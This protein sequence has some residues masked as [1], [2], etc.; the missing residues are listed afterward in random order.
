MINYYIFILTII[1]GFINKYIL[2]QNEFISSYGN[3]LLTML[4][5]L[6]FYSILF[7][8]QIKL[9]YGIILFIIVSILA[10]FVRPL[11]NLAPSVFDWLDI[12][13]YGVGMVIYYIII[14]VGDRKC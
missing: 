9:K 10:E 2:Y 13:A 12:V 8:K 6:S 4:V 7:R 3:D 1:L 11:V 5:L 14:Y